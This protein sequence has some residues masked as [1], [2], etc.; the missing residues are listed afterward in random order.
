[1]NAQSIAR[2]DRPPPARPAPS[3][4]ESLELLDGGT[5]AYPRMLLAIENATTSVYLEVYA[6]APTGVGHRFIVA[7]G[8]AARRGVHVSVILDAW[9]SALGGIRVAEALGDAGCKVQIY[10]GL[11]A[12]LRG[13]FGRNHRKVLLVD[14]N[15]AFIGG[16]NIGDE[17]LHRGKR[18]G[19]ADLAL[20]IKGPQCARLGPL[21]RGESSPYVEHALQLYL[22]GIGG[23]WRLRNRY[24]R[25]LSSAKKSILLAHGYFLPDRR[26]VRALT[27]AAK[28]GVSVQLLL[29]GDSD[30]PFARFATRSLYRTLLDSGVEIHEWQASVL[31]AKVAVVDG[32]S[33]LVGS[34]NLDPFSLANLEVLV[35]VREPNVVE[36]GETWIRDHFSRAHNATVE[37]ASS[38]IQRTLLDPFGRLIAHVVEILSRMIVRRR[39]P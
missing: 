35:E 26:I 34:F 13:R 11:S 32:S 39:R 27:D 10:N 8:D 14:D 15:I 31:H 28:R 16:I 38:W 29:S 7:L 18:F 22:S 6:F 3:G 21:L 20:E 9:G 5:E 19:W 2:N 24:L 23:G 37:E 1:M 33:L 4:T 36:Q 25:A 12:L 17:N 30:V